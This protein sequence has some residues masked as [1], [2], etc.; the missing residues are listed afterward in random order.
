MRIIKDAEINA[1]IMEKKVLPKDF[2]I[3]LRPKGILGHKQFSGN[4]M[5]ESGN[6]FR[7]I[8]RQNKD[9]PFDFSVILGVMIG[10]E[11][12]RL[13]RYNG[14]SHV[15]PNKIEKDETKE[16]HIHQATER[17]QEKGFKEEAFATSSKG[18]YDLDTAIHALFRENNFVFTG[19]RDQMEL[20]DEN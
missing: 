1:Y 10:G 20:K 12:F 13:K 7:I 5:G 18:Y 6:S 17:Y 4:I 16:F 15:H 3:M 19:G 11:M 8:V 9:F 2:K 14:N